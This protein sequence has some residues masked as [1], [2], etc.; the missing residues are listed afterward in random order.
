MPITQHWTYMD[1]SAVAPLPGATAEAIGSWCVQATN[2]GDTVWMSWHESVQRVR[3]L[4]S[5]LLNAE[6]REIALVPNTTAGISLVADGFPWE[7]GDNVVTVENEFPS[8]LYPW[9][10]QASRG[11]EVRVVEVE[12]GQVDVNRV[13]EAIDARTRIV[14]VSWIGYASGWRMDLADLARA[15]HARDALLFVD[16]IQGLGVFPLNVQEIPIDFLAAD[17]HKWMLGPEGAGLFYVRHKHLAQLRPIGVGWNSVC[18][19]FDFDQVELKLRDEAS[20]Y[21]GGSQNMVGFIG[22]GASLDLLQRFGLTPDSSPI[23][24]RVLQLGDYAADQLQAVGAELITPRPKDHRSG[25]ITFRLPRS[26]PQTLRQACQRAKIAVSC[27]GGGLRL[28]PHAY[29]N[30]DEIDHLV[31]TV[32]RV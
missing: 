9:L 26:D 6:P 29:N 10:N 11:V 27:R 15:T 17:G 18:N 32:T 8:N 2:S 16:A 24:D 4:A 13:V 7:Q 30:E 14:A 23:A 28:S 19:A 12:A 5:T 25:I 22:L 1:H 31:K 21:E 20:R 3:Q